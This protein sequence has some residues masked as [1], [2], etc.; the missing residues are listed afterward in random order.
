[1]CCLSYE[2][3]TYRS[4]KEKFPKIGKKINTTGGKGKVIRHNVMR[5]RIV[6]RLDEGTEIETGIDTIMNE[7]E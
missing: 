4:F 6:I 3:E 5:N 2:N 7:K 1:M